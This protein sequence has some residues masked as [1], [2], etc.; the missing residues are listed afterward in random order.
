L[1]EHPPLCR[2]HPR[3][4]RVNQLNL[5]L[6][7]K[8]KLKEISRAIHLRIDHDYTSATIIAL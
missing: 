2:F 8:R 4:A 1:E 7:I 6:F 3:S 5:H